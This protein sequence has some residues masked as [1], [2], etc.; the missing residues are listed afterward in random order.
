MSRVWAF[1][2]VL[3]AHVVVRDTT[4]KDYEGFVRNVHENAV[5]L[6]NGDGT[7]TVIDLE[8][9]VSVRVLP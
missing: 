8:Y 5:V 6:A 9:I 7:A 4:G 2:D 1:V 3:S